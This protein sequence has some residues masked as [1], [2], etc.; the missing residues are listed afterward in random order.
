MTGPV[1][2][3]RRASQPLHP[4]FWVGLELPPEDVP[5]PETVEAHFAYNE[6][7]RDYPKAISLT[8]R[9]GVIGKLQ[10]VAT[11]LALHISREQGIPDA[12][13]LMRFSGM[14]ARVL[15]PL[16]ISIVTPESVAV[17][18]DALDGVLPEDVAALILSD[19]LRLIEGVRP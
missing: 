15:G 11:I 5:F 2:S 19:L 1:C 4:E 14:S 3:E 10:I 7:A 18:D 12:R 16:P 13:S 17:V 8:N 9:I 6:V